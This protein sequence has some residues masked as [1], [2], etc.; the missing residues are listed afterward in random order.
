MMKIT[1]IGFA[2]LVLLGLNALGLSSGDTRF[3]SVNDFKARHT[4]QR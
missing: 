3:A 4:A 2:L 1:L